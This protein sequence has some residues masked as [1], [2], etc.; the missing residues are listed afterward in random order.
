M[1]VWKPVKG[2]E[3]YYEVSNTGL[4]KSLARVLPQS[5]RN[6][7]TFI[8]TEKIMRSINHCRGYHAVQLTI[9]KKVSRFLVHRLV[10][11]HF[12]DRPYG[13]NQVNHINGVKTDNRVENLEWVTPQ[14]NST[15]ALNLGLMGKGWFKRKIS[16][17][18]AKEIR[19][20]VN[21][22]VT[23]KEAGLRYGIAQATVTNIINQRRSYAAYI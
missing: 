3:G 18:N 2:F 8:K 17:E 9:N 19:A 14:E 1:I 7:A 5:R 13:K 15:H 12:I 23:H 4:I 10:A 20:L 11:E 16:P 6:G 22:G 21:T